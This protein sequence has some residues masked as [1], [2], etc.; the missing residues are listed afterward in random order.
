MKRIGRRWASGLGA[1]AILALVSCV[2]AQAAPR[3]AQSTPP[4]LVVFI[5]VDQMRADYFDRFGPQLTGGLKRLRD[6]G[7]FFINGFQDHGVTQTAPG[8]AATLSGRFPVHTGIIM[9]SLGVNDAPDA[10]VLG[11][12]KGE[13][14]SPFRFRGTTLIDWVRAKDPSAR[15]LSV[16]RKDRG[17]ILPIGRSKGNVF[18]YSPTGDFTTSRYYADTLPS[19][20]QAFNAASL[21]YDYAGKSWSLLRDAKTYPEPDSVGVEASATGGDYT[22]PHAVPRELERAAAALPAYPFMDEVTLRFA[23][24]GVHALGL[25]EQ[26]GRTDL[27]AISLSTTDAVGHRWGPDSREMHDQIL[28]LDQYLGVFLD[29]LVAVRGASRLLVALTADHGV[30]PLPELKSTIYP[31]GDAKRVT[32]DLPWKAFQARLLAAGVDTSAVVMQDGLVGIANPGAFASVRVD[33]D[34]MLRDLKRDFERVQG[35]ARAD[36]MTDLAKA[37]TVHDTIARRWLHSFSPRSGIRLVTSLAPYSYWL[38]VAYATHGSPNDPDA[39]VPVLF[40]GADVVPGQYADTVRVVDMAPTLAK[41]LGVKPLEPTDG[42]VLTQ[43][44]VPR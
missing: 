40:W 25:G 1:L 27:L 2:A 30:S 13:T 32:L 23:L 41:I 37:D 14:A 44:I 35:V 43:V 18:W 24:H 38:P 26:S 16:S 8:H 19:W 9:N 33:A 3:Q 28:R 22:F 36:L 15:W 10:Q 6:G 34:E 29:S 21:P 39:N 7:A 4:T 20:V 12:R 42:H 17:A 31:N 11:G 5:T